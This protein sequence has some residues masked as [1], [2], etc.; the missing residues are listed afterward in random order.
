MQPWLLLSVYEATP[1]FSHLIEASVDE[2]D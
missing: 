1:A 2:A